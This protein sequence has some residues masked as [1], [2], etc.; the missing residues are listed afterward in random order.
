[1]KGMEYNKIKYKNNIGIHMYSFF[2]NN[3]IGEYNE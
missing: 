2:V 1:M 3:N